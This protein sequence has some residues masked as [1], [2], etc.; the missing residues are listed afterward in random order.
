MAS[1]IAQMGLP[2]LCGIAWGIIKPSGL[3][4]ELTRRVLTTVV[5]N[6]LLPALVLSVLWRSDIG[7]ESLKISL[8]GVGIVIF[9]MTLL[10][11]VTKPF[12]IDK[13]RLGAALL[14]A[15][16]PN[17][18]Y[19]G[20]PVLE[21]AF[22]PWVRSL[23]IQI[24]L[25]ATMPM[26]LVM[27]S[28][29][30]RHYG[31]PTEHGGNSTFRLIATNPPLLSA[32][33]AVLLNVFG[34]PLPAWLGA[35][36]D[37]LAAAVIPL[38]LLSL[39]MGL[40]WSALCWRNATLSCL[41]LLCRL[42]IVPLVGMYLAQGLGFSGDKLTALVM[43]AGMPCMMIGVVFCDRYKLDTAF[44]SMI[45]VLSTILGMISVA[46]WQGLLS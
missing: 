5:F 30:G 6:L 9:G 46:T 14:G 16:F 4:A 13:R 17:V 12:Q 8:Y 44:Y 22:G 19:L 43:E 1:L 24:D 3:D 34:I 20:L 11:V 31:S 15:A 21:Q 35:M 37:K 36:L 45:V 40:N 28:I 33:M 7:M 18:T 26:V 23:V 38:M 39:G 25:F 29:I 32:V 10:W 42:I 41:V 2:I 27:S